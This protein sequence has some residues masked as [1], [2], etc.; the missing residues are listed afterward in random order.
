MRRTRLLTPSLVG[1]R[2]PQPG[3]RARD[4]RGEQSFAIDLVDRLRESCI[5]QRGT[6]HLQELGA[7]LL[8]DVARGHLRLHD[9][10][11]GGQGQAL[12]DEGTRR[13]EQRDREEQSAHRS[14][15][16]DCLSGGQGDG[17]TH[18]CPDDD[19]ALARTQRLAGEIIQVGTTHRI[20]AFATLEATAVVIECVYPV[21]RAQV[22]CFEHV[23]V[24]LAG[25][26]H[27][28]LEAL[29]ARAL[30]L[31]AA[32]A[33]AA[34]MIQPGE[35]E[36]NEDGANHHDERAEGD[37]EE[38]CEGQA[39][40]EL[41]GLLDD[42]EGLQAHRQENPALQNE[43]HG[44]PVL[45]GETPVVRGDNSRATTRDNQAGDDGGDQAGPSQVLGGDR[46]DEGHHE[47][48]DRVR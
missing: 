43:G 33:V 35:H 32:L 19:A 1:Q 14:V 21:L 26:V 6:H 28:L 10:D 39:T 42:A 47:G 7:F 5:H 20:A 18:S 38:S 8:G 34:A 44:L 46:R 37:G 40:G 22:T 25:L 24:D 15:R 23:G 36:R 48:E 12:D 29:D 11:E 4:A 30:N 31:V 2:V 9:A 41:G 3:Q 45:L 27:A 16:R 13:D 17:T